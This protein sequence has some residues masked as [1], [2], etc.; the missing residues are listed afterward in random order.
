MSSNTRWWGEFTFEVTQTR[1]W[2]V[3][4][5]SIFIQC[6][7]LQWLT[8]L[9][10]AEMTDGAEQ[11]IQV[12]EVISTATLSE[13]NLIRHLHSDS[14]GTIII[15][16]ALA[17]RSVVA[18]PSVPLHL[19]A[20]EKTTIYV[21][22]PLWFTAKTPADDSL[23]L[24]VPFYRPSDSWFG[25]STIKGELCYAKYTDARLDIAMLERHAHRAITPIRIHNEKNESMA[26]ERLNVPIPY[27]HLYADKHNDLWTDAITLIREDD[28]ELAEV[29]LD[30]CPPNV[31]IEACLVAEPRIASEQNRF[32]RN[33]GNLFA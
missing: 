23:I 24:D 4:S 26:I 1:C 25:L 13:S 29:K 14:S 2:S 3:G 7:E 11:P 28:G 22:T 27:L 32:I 6:H 20:G 21:S 33:I 30:K 31:A 10:K 17:D 16:P 5:K 9:S 19:L 18:R 15:K 12:E 8:W